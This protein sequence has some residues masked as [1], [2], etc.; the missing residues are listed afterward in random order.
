[1]KKF[2]RNI[3]F[4]E[5]VLIL[6][7]LVF[8]TGVA[9]NLYSDVAR[10]ARL[11]S[12]LSNIQNVYNA[13]ILF[14][15]ENSYRLPD[16]FDTLLDTAGAINPALLNTGPTAVP[17]LIVQDLNDMADILDGVVGGGPVVGADVLNDLQNRGVTE[18][19]YA[20]PTFTNETLGVGVA[21][22]LLVVGDEFCVI[23]SSVGSSGETLLHNLFNITV[24]D[25]HVYLCMGI[26]SNNT[27]I[28]SSSGLGHAP[29]LVPDVP[30]SSSVTIDNNYFRFVNVYEY[31]TTIALN[32]NVTFVLELLGTVYPNDIEVG[33][34]QNDAFLNMNSLFEKIA[35]ENL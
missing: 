35:E 29:V 33:S 13:S 7:I 2:Q 12:N 14:E 25:D 24:Q 32:G 16:D 1:M 17:S 23:D 20:L 4:V 27:L 9:I 3:S 10:R 26:N 28:G 8:L 22:P 18:I 31:S 15:I 30:K 19:R 6:L 11:V 21:A 34:P 5:L